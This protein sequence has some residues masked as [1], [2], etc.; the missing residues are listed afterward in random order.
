[1]SNEISYK[2]QAAPVPYLFDAVLYPSRSLGRQG[3]MWLMVVLLGCSLAVGGLFWSRGAWPVMGFY[4][5]EIVIV[6]L[7]FRANYIAGRDYETIRLTSNELIVEDHSR[8]QG[9]KRWV[10]NPARVRVEIKNDPEHES[11]LTITAYGRGVAA[12]MFLS[13]QE[14][15]DVAKALRDALYAACGNSIDK[16]Q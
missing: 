1:M 16:T 10:F 8:R 11:A 15:Q 7:A 3:F 4:G 6:W 14:R 9:Q 13:P 12:G 2:A 5:L